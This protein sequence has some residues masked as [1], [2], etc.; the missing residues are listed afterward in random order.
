MTLGLRALTIGALAATVVLGV[1]SAHAATKC[2]MSFRLEGWSAF[3]KTSHGTGRVTCDNGQARTVV[4]RTKGGG[5]TFGASKIVNGHGEFSPV[6]DVREIYGDYANADVHAG[7]GKSADAQVV[8]KGSVSL[9]LSGKGRGINL[10]FAFGKFTI[11]PS[12]ARRRH[13]G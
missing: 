1:A 3:Y 8:T 10:G 5:V 12:R 4:L 13:R 6:D 2:E 11:T 9:A 7:A